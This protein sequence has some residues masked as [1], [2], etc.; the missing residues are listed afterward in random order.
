MSVGRRLNV[1]LLAQQEQF[2]C[3]PTCVKM[4]ME[5]MNQSG[6]LRMPIPDLSIREIAK[7]VKEEDG[8]LASDVPLINEH[9]A[10]ASPSVEF[11]DEFRFRTVNEMNDEISKGLP[12][13]AWQYV[14]DGVR[15]H[16]HAVVV[17]DIDLEARRITYNDPG[18][19]REHSE[20]LDDFERKWLYC[21]CDLLKVQIG[22]NTKIDEFPS[23]TRD[24]S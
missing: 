5:Y 3:V 9:I 16:R 1:P 6:R 11:E 14:G 21:G 8:T 13:I 23:E 17:T 15:H 20:S 22:R 2:F 18:P 24:G 19:P 4:V 7:I 10:A 12:C